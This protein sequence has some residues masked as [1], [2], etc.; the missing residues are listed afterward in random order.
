MLETKD[1]ILK[2]GSESDWESLYE[3]LWSRP[4]T[5]TWMFQKP[6][7]S[8]EHAREKTAAWVSMHREV[9]T[10]FFIY[11]KETGKAIGIAGLKAYSPTLY[12]VTDIALGPNYWRRG[13]GKQILQA[14][15]QFGWELGAEQV[16][17]NCFRENSASR[18]LALSCGYRYTKSEEAEIKKNGKT[19]WLDYFERT[20]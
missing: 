12:T 9:P 14:L 19:V 16:L 17:F 11:L 20:R 7:P 5:F 18:S 10:E 6:S 4:E 8:P 3:C 2:S 15:T 13:Y 1:L